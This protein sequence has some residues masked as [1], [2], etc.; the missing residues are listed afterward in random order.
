MKTP[1]SIINAIIAMIFNVVILFGILAYFKANLTLP[2]IAGLILAAAA[3]LVT[4]DWRLALSAL[5]LQYLCLGLILTRF[6]P[7]EAAFVRIL[8]GALVV[9]ILYLSARQET[10][11]SSARPGEGTEQRFLGLPMGWAAESLGDLTRQVWTLYPKDTRRSEHPAPFPEALPN[12]LIALYTFA[13]GM[14]SEV[15]TYV[16]T[17]SGR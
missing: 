1:F 5:L 3:I 13:G 4:S 17:S 7:P 12:R 11:A 14:P 2:G 9:P 16:S 10:G 8:T 6:I 15:A